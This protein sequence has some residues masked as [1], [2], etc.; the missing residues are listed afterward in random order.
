[1]KEIIG[2]KDWLLFRLIIPVFPDL[3]VFTKFAKSMTALGPIMV[4]TAVNKLWGWRVEVID[5]NNYRGPRDEQGLPDHQ[6]LQK[7]NPAYAVGFYCGL[8]STIERVWQLAEFYQGQNVFTIAGGWHAHYCPEETLRKNV[9]IV[10]HGD[11]EIVIKQILQI[12]AKHDSFKD[13]SGIS[14]LENGNVKT[15]EPEMIENPCLDDLPIPD[16]GL[17]THANKITIYPIGRIRG[18]GMHCE[19][20]SVKGN[21]RWASANHLFETVSWL[22]AT[23][24]ASHFFIV[25]DR[26]EQ[27][28]AGTMD[29]FRMVSERYGNRLNF[30]VQI[31]LEAAKNTELLEVMKRAGVR[32]VCIGYESPIDEELRAMR[33]GYLSAKMLEWTRIYR[34]YGFRI[35]AMFIFGYPLKEGGGLVGIEGRVKRYKWFIRKAGFYTIQILHAFPI[36]GT[37]LRK[38]LQ[39]EQRI[40]PL[41]LVPWSRYDGNYICFRPDDMTLQE[42][43]EIPMRIMKWF[44]SP[45]SFVGVF[46]KTIAFPIDF[47]LLGWEHWYRHWYRDVLVYGAYIL[48]R[49][50]QKRQR[51]DDFLKRL[52][53]HFLSP[54]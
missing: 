12:I 24:K 48:I 44:Y 11:A 37:E 36:V 34:S 32:V 18:C 45:L 27:D 9:N 17:L 54:K 31:R 38:R 26:L 35:H 50:W 15:N 29:F 19:F 42:F 3:N 40:F 28:L 43:Q 46:I 8:T 5:E 30:T 23:K 16:F 47:L 13:V 33:K 10:V 52:Q 39:E 53:E 4:A 14:F 25:D 6:S 21:P 41:A 2:R 7:E 49:R 51:G 22:V 20:C 1:M